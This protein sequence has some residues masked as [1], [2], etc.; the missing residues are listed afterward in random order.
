MAIAQRHADVLLVEDSIA[1]AHLIRG[2]L[3]GGD[4]PASVHHVVD[5]VQAMAFLRREAPYGG[6]PRPDLVLLDLNMPR[7]DGREVL[8]EIK[9]DPDLFS[10]PVIPLT[11]SGD[12][13]DVAF[14]YRAGANAFI[15]KPMDLDELDSCL[16]TVQAFWFSKATLPSGRRP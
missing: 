1:D 10:I 14:C 4:F 12:E 13:Q 15:T 5:G 16:K 6:A 2:F 3:I 9:S 8:T 7:K 11:T